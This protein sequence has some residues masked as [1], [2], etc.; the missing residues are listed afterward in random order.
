[1]T[2]DQWVSWISLALAIMAAWKQLKRLAQQWVVRPVFALNE[3]SR[4]KRRS[5]LN[6]RRAF[7]T[8][9]HDSLEEQNTYL[10]QGMLI[11][12]T[13]AAATVVLG[14]NI[15]M[16]FPRI[17][18]GYTGLCALLIYFFALYRLGVHRR[19]RNPASFGKAIKQI[20]AQIAAL[21]TD[22]SRGNAGSVVE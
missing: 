16:N 18:A 10:L 12:L 22:D 20:D 15:W 1:M 6:A 13:G 11:A 4:Q 7:L 3:R 9:L 2:M 17:L 19:V 5:Q 8:K 21:Q 14:V